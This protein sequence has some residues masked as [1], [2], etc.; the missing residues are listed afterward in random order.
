MNFLSLRGLFAGLPDTDSLLESW[1][2]ELSVI[3]HI[4]LSVDT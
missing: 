4:L 3:F 1:P 2:E